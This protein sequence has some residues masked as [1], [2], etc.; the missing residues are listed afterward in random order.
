MTEALLVSAELDDHI[1]RTPIPT[2][3]AHSANGVWVRCATCGGIHYATV[4]GSA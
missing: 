3:D 1:V 4:E 2:A